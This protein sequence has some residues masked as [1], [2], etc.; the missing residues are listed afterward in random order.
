MSA[1]A[2]TG[3]VN[4]EVA[5]AFLN[6]QGIGCIGYPVAMFIAKCAFGDSRHTIAVSF[7]RNALMF[8]AH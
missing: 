8:P 6:D 2:R 3:A 1:K 4:D 7:K 5:K